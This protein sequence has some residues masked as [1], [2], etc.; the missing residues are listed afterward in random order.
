[1]DII[2][3]FIAFPLNNSYDF[4]NK[5]GIMRFLFILAFLF[6]NFFSNTVWAYDDQD[7]YVVKTCRQALEVATDECAH[8]DDPDA[9]DGDD[10]YDETCVAKTM[11]NYGYSEKDY[12]VEYEDLEPRPTYNEYYCL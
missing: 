6:S 11:K 5:G 12:T 3:K 9:G 4:A 7:G 2:I 10:W 1:M 8:Y